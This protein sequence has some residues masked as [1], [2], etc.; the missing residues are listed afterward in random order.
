MKVYRF[1][2]LAAA[3][4]I[5]SCAAMADTI[6]PAI[7]VKGAGG[8]M[9]WTGSATFLIADG[10]PGASCDGPCDFT[11]PTFF[12]EVN[13]TSFD[14]VFDIVQGPF[15]P[16]E[17]SAFPNVDTIVPGLVARL[18]GGTI[19]P[20]CDGECFP[21]SNQIFGDFAFTL[22]GVVNGSTVTISTT[23]VPEP[24]TM[25]LLGS[26]LAAMGLRRRRRKKAESEASSVS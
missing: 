2:I 15:S 4:A 11:S 10:Q 26:G 25:I 14:L 16:L 3:A 22:Q 23:P 24:G 6:D 20:P 13:L 17:G 5:F 12:S 1:L 9:Q 18:S 8:S 21:T 19:F 7:G